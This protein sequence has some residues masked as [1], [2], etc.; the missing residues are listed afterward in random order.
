ME[1]PSIVVR[2]VNL[3]MPFFSTWSSVSA[4]VKIPKVPVE[5]LVLNGK[6]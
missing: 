6:L 1:K 4:G 3:P 5:K 2:E